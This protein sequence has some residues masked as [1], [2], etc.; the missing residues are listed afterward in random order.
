MSG[1]AFDGLDE[2]SFFDRVQA[3]FSEKAPDLSKTL[4]IAIIGKVSSGKSSL[5]N[6]LLQHS[7]R[8]ALEMAKV[9]AISGVTKGLTIF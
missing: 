3:K 6:A 8:Q 2:N 5:I 9:G 7:R 1:S 4:N